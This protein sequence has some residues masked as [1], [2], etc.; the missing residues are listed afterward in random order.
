MNISLKEIILF[1]SDILQ[2]VSFFSG[3]PGEADV[4]HNSEIGKSCSYMEGYRLMR[5]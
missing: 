3:T 5:L 4:N 1:N 2:F